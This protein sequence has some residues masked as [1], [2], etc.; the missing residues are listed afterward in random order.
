MPRSRA[1][2]LD[3]LINKYPDNELLKKLVEE[4]ATYYKIKKIKES[5]DYEG[6]FSELYRVQ[7]KTYSEIAAEFYVCG[8]TIK[9]YSRDEYSDLAKKLIQADYIS[10]LKKQFGRYTSP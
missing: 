1:S 9:N 2:F 4:M 3:M 7:R 6:I 5:I 10:G 8:D